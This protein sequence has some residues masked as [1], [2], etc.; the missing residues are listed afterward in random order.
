VEAYNSFTVESVESIPGTNQIRFVLSNNITLMFDYYYNQWGT[1]TNLSAISSTIY[2]GYQTY[3]N[4]FGQILQETPGLYM[5]GSNPVIMSLTTSWI[6]VAGLQGYER[7]Y[8]MLL[9]GTYYTPF[10]LNVGLSY[11]YSSAV[12]QQTLVTPNNYVAP[13]GGEANWGAGG[14]WGGSGNVFEA[15]IFP[16]TQKCETFQVTIN[17]IFDGTYPTPN[18]GQGLT[19]SGMNLV[20]G[21]KKGYRTNKASQSFG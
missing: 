16:Q 21:V 15:R 3:L 2:Q 14:P 9:L 17:E 18:G 10:K 5:D 4:K 7:F 12:Q 8:Q 11:D 20:V 19:L 13:W 6:S 1:F